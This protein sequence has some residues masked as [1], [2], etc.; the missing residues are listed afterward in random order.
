MQILPTSCSVSVNY[1]TASRE[2]TRWD[3]QD[4]HANLIA[5]PL[6]GS[7]AGTHCTKRTFVRRKEF[8]NSSF[9]GM[10]GDGN[11]KRHG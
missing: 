8:L 7:M 2:Q 5:S 3:L 4:L 9:S 6:L 1:L 11:E 10:A